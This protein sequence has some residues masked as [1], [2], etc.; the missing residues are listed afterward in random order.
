MDHLPDLAADRAALRTLVDELDGI[1]DADGFVVPPHLVMIVGP[2]H[3]P[4]S[5]QKVIS[6]LDG[7]PCADALLGLTAPPE[8]WA[9][10]TIASGWAS[11][12]EAFDGEEAERGRF[13]IRPS[14]HP[15]ACRMRGLAMISRAGNH[16]GRIRLANGVCHDHDVGPADDTATG[17]TVD[18]IRRA[19]GLPTLPPAFPTI[20]LFTTLWLSDIAYLAQEK[21][22]AGRAATWNQIARLHPGMRML[23][24]GGSRVRV[25]E[26]VPTARA[27]GKVATWSVVRQQVIEK[28]WLADMV[29]PKV[30][31]WMDE[32]MLA[33]WLIGAFPPVEAMLAQVVEDLRDPVAGQLTEAVQELVGSPA[34]HDDAH[35]A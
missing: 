22:A 10:G 33:R 24:T 17:V 13:A 8:W 14:A 35:V 15:D 1:F 29:E 32:G 4:S 2:G 34:A 27:L 20:E 3:D 6:D 18:G 28:R 9:L 21:R 7:M 26:L 25:E 11:P 12:P 31:E 16:V 23:N 19:L 30:A 5:W